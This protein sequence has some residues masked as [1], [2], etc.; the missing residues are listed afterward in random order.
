MSCD[1]HSG[2]H[3]FEKMVVANASFVGRYERIFSRIGYPADNLLCRSASGS[4]AAGTLR[5][6]VDGKGPL[7][8]RLAT[9]WKPS[10]QVTISAI[11]ENRFMFQFYHYWDM[12]RVFHGGTPTPF[13]I[14][15]R[16]DRCVDRAE[17]GYL[18]GGNSVYMWLRGGP[19]DTIGGRNAGAMLMLRMA[20]AFFMEDAK[21]GNIHNN[22]SMKQWVPITFKEKDS[23]QPAAMNS[24]SQCEDKQSQ[25]SKNAGLE[26]IPLR[27]EGGTEDTEASN[28]DVWM[29]EAFSSKVTKDSED[30]T[31]MHNNHLFSVTD[32]QRNDMKLKE[33]GIWCAKIPPKIKNL[34]WRIG[35]NC[36]PTQERLASHG[37]MCPV[38]CAGCDE[39]IEDNIHMFFQCTQSSI[40]WQRVECVKDGGAVLIPIDR[41]GTILQLLEEM[42]TLHETSAMEDIANPE[43]ALLPFKP[44]AMKKV[45]PL[46]KTPQPKIVLQWRAY[47]DAGNSILD[48]PCPLGLSLKKGLSLSE[49]DD[50]DSRVRNTLDVDRGIRNKPNIDG[51]MVF[52]RKNCLDPANRNGQ[53]NYKFGL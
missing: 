16:A 40:C 13:R 6:V 31:L 36:L 1:R 2:F 52:A 4:G 33:T 28:G 43:L 26:V 44:V 51:N 7:K 39:G 17:S 25:N 48:E 32:A 20:L 21:V 30:I 14:H 50:M 49:L 47:E 3:L 35:R 10:Q 46:L 24:G 37:V 38:N 22:E 42:T 34:L 45:Q 27:L 8:N 53:A 29:L 41:L 15:E 5:A 9:L 19:N 12:E 11:D 23:Q 18:G